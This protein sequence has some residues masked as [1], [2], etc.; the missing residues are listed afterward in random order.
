MS[1]L[2][3]ERAS[4]IEPK[5]AVTRAGD[6]ATITPLETSPLG[7]IPEFR[8]F[9][10]QELGA[11]TA[12]VLLDLRDLNALSPVDLSLLACFIRMLR[13]FQPKARVELLQANPELGRFLHAMEFDTRFGIRVVAAASPDPQP[14]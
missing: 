14:S 8:S 7:S 10:R 12:N 6:R 4:D 9:L 1:A 5:F 11:R 2:Q 3:A 13:E